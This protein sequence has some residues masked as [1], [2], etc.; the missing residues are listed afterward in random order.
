MSEW[1]SAFA[2]KPLRRDGGRADAIDGTGR[3]IAFLRQAARAEF[4]IAEVR[5]DRQSSL[6]NKRT[7]SAAVIDGKD[8]EAR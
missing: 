7:I 1:L 4:A 5:D 2:A 3:Q 6:L 8:L